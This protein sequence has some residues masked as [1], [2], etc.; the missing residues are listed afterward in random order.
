[1]AI[2]TFTLASL[3]QPRTEYTPP[4]A[5]VVGITTVCASILVVSVLVLTLVD[6]LF[7]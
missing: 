4:R 2:G 3:F 1:M 7:P 6:G 5:I